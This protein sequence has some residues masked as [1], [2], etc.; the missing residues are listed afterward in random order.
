MVVSEE[1][2]STI[3]ICHRGFEEDEV[4]EASQVFTENAVNL[5][6]CVNEWRT[7]KLNDASKM[8]F[9]RQAAKLR[10]ESPGSDLVDA[11]L[12]PHR[13]E[14]NDSSLWSVFNRVQEN[15][16]QGGFLNED[17][18]R[19]VRPITAIKKNVNINSGLWSIASKYNR[20]L[21]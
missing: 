16:L 8:S 17:T 13:P 19:R 2:F 11:L 4:R 9:S 12:V 18:R 15:L 6:Q 1:E 10:F 20:S 7:V 3:R 14:D 5:N 21:N